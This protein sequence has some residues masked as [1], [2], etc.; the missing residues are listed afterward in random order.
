M[1]DI[2]DRWQPAD[3]RCKKAGH[4][5]IPPNRRWS[6]GCWWCVLP[7]SKGSKSG[8]GEKRFSS[9]HRLYVQ[10]VGWAVFSVTQGRKE[11]Q[12]RQM[13]TRKEKALD[14]FCI[15]RGL[16][17]WIYTLKRKR[18]TSPSCITYSLPSERTRPFS[19]AAAME[20]LAIRSSKEM[21]SARM[22]PRSKSL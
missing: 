19:L 18:T 10:P 11:N 5:R 3:C 2:S 9:R 4:S 22:K 16:L 12:S 20:P 14:R 8:Q 15:G 6:T 21:T 13:G 7:G 1:S 17:F